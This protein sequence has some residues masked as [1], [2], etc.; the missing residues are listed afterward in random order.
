LDALLLY[1]AILFIHTFTR[2][3]KQ[4]VAISTLEFGVAFGL[5]KSIILQFFNLFGLGGV[6]AMAVAK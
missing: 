3:P 4:F 2:R 6:D 5:N 1:T